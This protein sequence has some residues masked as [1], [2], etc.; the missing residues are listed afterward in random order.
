MEFTFS[1]LYT[2]IIVLL[3]ITLYLFLKLQSTSSKSPDHIL[4]SKQEEISKLENQLEMTLLTHKNELQNYKIEFQEAHKNSVKEATKRSNDSQRSILKGQIA[5]QYAPFI[6][7]FA[8]TP[9]DCQFLGKP[10]D[11]IIFNNLH[12]CSEGSV[13]IEKVEIIFAEVKTGKAQ[14]NKRQKIL[15]EAIDN[16][17]V[18]FETLRISEEIDTQKIIIRSDSAQVSSTTVLASVDSASPTIYT[19]HGE[20]WSKKEDI[21]LT[22]LFHQDLPI[23]E[24]MSIHKRNKGGI[25]SRLKRLGLTA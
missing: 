25:Q 24:I 23:D 3:F 8:Y 21:Q 11:Y 14:H 9:A 22:E 18:R 19:R 13:D 17:R 4:A 20:S 10:I 6:S 15:K 7:G 5:E 2:I 16:G 12:D 1:W